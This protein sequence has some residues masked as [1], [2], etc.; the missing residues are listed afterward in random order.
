[1]NSL[2]QADIFFFVTSLTIVAVAI[3]FII[4]LIFLIQILRDVH[5]VSGRIRE[6][7]DRVFQDVEDL[8]GFIKRE[9]QK[10]V[11]LKELVG[12]I[13]GALLAKKKS[14]KSKRG[15]I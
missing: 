9:G 1:M 11:N 12:G 13:I 14:H 7:S 8:R 5:H 3:A 4:A 2:L 10:A 6:Q 15:N